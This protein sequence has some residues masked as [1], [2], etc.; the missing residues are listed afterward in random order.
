MNKEL[1]QRVLIICIN[2]L[3]NVNNKGEVSGI[4]MEVYDA[5]PRIALRMLFRT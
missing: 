5:T 4:V 1:L 3:I 2:D